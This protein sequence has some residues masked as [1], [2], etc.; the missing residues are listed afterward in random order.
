MPKETLTLSE[1]TEQQFLTISELNAISGK[2][3][4]REQD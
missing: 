2:V 1:K 4:I 3:G